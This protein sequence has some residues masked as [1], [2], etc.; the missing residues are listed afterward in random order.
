[1]HED[2]IWNKRRKENFVGDILQFHYAGV[3]FSR[4]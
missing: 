2:F 3:R 4:I 1:M